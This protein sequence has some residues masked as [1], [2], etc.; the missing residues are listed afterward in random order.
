MAISPAGTV[1][2]LVPDA[3]PRPVSEPSTPTQSTQADNPREAVTP[4]SSDTRVEPE[5]P[6]EHKLDLSV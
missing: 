2:T 4:P 3:P 6:R 1:S 5:P